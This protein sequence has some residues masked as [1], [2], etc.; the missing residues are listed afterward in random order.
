MSTSGQGAVLDRMDT[1]SHPSPGPKGAEPPPSP[2]SRDE[3]GAADEGNRP[4]A[5]HR[6]SELAEWLGLDRGEG[7]LPL[8]SGPRASSPAP[9]GRGAAAGVY[10]TPEGGATRIDLMTDSNVVAGQLNNHF[11][12]SEPRHKVYHARTA[13]LLATVEKWRVQH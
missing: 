11:K 13:K 6:I 10:H 12:V 9:A 2:S 3:A 5:S 1:T 8:S 4:G 7:G